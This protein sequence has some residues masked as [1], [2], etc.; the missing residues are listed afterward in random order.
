[1]TKFCYG[2]IFA[3]AAV[4]HSWWDEF[5]C[6]CECFRPG[7]EL[8]AS[9]DIGMCAPIVWLPKAF[10]CLFLRACSARVRLVELLPS[11][12]PL[13]CW[14]SQV[15]DLPSCAV[16]HVLRLVYKLFLHVVASRVCVLVDICASLLTRTLPLVAS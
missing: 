8:A 12:L 16:A 7:D 2:S 6:H 14:W 5:G 15:C 10:V 13:V 3:L 9:S 1:M 11:L 4:F